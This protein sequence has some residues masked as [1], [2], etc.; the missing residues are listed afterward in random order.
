MKKIMECYEF[1]R[2]HSKCTQALILIMLLNMVAVG[3]AQAE[4]T[5]AGQSALEKNAQNQSV[6]GKVTDTDG[7]AL[8]GVNVIEKGTAN[9]TITDM[10]GNYSVRI[11]SENVILVYS[12]VGYISKEILVG[13]QTVIDVSL[14]ADI[15]SLSEVIVVGYGTMKKSDLT[16]STVSADIESFR[17]SPN[18]NIMQSLQGS[19]PGVTIGQT[20]TTTGEP[21]IEVRGVSTLNGNNDVLIIV[22]GFIFSGRFGDINPADVKSVEIL[23][24]ASS[25]AIY[26]AQAANGVILVTTKS[27]NYKRKPTFTYSGSVATSSPTVNANLLR[28]DQFLQKV[29]DLEWIDS[30]TVESGYTEENPAWDIYSSDMTP[31]LV[32]GF[33]D[34]SDFDWYDQLTRPALITSHT[35]GATGGSDEIKYYLSAGYTDNK[36]FIKGDDYTRWT[37]RLSLDAKLSNW[38]TIGTNSSY[39]FTDFSGDAP[40]INQIVRTSPL[41]EPYDQ[42]GN[43]IINPVGDVNTNPLLPITN[44]D[45]EKRNRFVGNFYALA[46]IPGVDGLTYR[47]NFGNNLVFSRSFGSSIYG[48]GQTGSAFKNNAYQFEQTLDNI[49]NYTKE[50]GPHS[51]NATFVYGW[52]TAEYERTS[53]TGEGYSDLDLSYNNLALA[54]N[55]RIQSSAWDES[56]LYQMARVAYNY[57]N[58]Y[59]FTA[60]VRRDGY[61]AFSAN[62]KSA[63]F[64]S[65]GLGWAISE[66]PFMAMP[67]ISYL[68]LRASYGE[69]G[70]RALRYSSLAVV[71]A[72]GGSNYVFGDG[73]ATSV[74]RSVSSLE[75]KDLKWEKT[76]GYNFGLD[77]SL[78][79]DRISGNVEY[80]DSRTRDLL[81]TQALPELSGFRNITTNLGELQNRG[82]EMFIKGTPVA[83]TNFTW[84]ISVSYYKNNNKV[85]SLLGED[86]DG[87]GKEDDLIGSN[88]FIGESI[89]TIYSYQTD[90][91]WQVNE[92]R[93][94][95]F[96]PGSYR[97][98]DQNNDGQIS[99]END[100]IIL[101][102]REPAFQLGIQNT[103]T[104]KQFSFRFFINSIQGGKDGY[105][106]E[107]HADGG[108]NTKGNATNA[109]WFDFYNYWSPVRPDAEYSNPWVGSPVSGS[110]R[111]FVQRNFVRLQDI[112]LSYS[113][114][115][116]LAQRLGL[117]SLKLFVSGKTC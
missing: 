50:F 89:G 26:G 2:D 51:V 45:L 73:S 100:R 10:D 75:N 33:E 70:N 20:N 34:G 99:P 116:D 36:G 18:V 28:R 77:F 11:S 78:F 17:E 112:S 7:A 92:E 61:S 41:V 80:Y 85:V 54:E 74:G 76:L 107:N 106:R 32:R 88:L 87:D 40:N 86:L 109:N 72:G 59:I 19:V 79:N 67:Q 29:R 69:N 46:N 95:G 1:L 30:Y 37:I 15:T 8:P 12:Y 63:I 25:K 64:P 97:V 113:F 93:P 66:E 42:D 65:I 104:Y 27:G 115:D 3:F 58:R 5:T 68:K 71:E 83:N 14:E 4:L 108:Y 6:S 96:E 21:S 103:L 22:D 56:L 52:N 53:S 31:P 117:G 60:T 23:K 57:E 90:G 101:G 94:D 111:R 114:K 38:L 98:I 44:D 105:L 102:R 43:L 110:A 62:N 48:G 35:F 39:T 81:W 47:I 13:T 24:D 49:V 16:G 91:L 84:D 55:Q 9:G 82:F